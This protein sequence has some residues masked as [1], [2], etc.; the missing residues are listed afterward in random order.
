MKGDSIVIE[1]HHH[2]AAKLIVSKLLSVI[3][4]SSH[5]TISV[6]GESGSGKSETAEAI[7]MKLQEYDINAVILQQDD[8]YFL[9]PKSNDMKRRKDSNWFGKKEVNI[10]LLSEH[11]ANF[12]Q[13]AQSISKP[14]VVYHE[15]KI[16][17]EE[18]S[19]EGTKVLIAEG[20]YTT[21]L[22]NVDCHIFIDRNYDKTREHRE[23]RLR[24]KSE[25]DGF[26]EQILKNEH[27]EISQQKKMADI[28]IDSD[29]KI[30]G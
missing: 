9:P 25:L 22:S 24:A 27:L 13:G 29:Y 14:M 3:K 7:A 30:V 16:E 12:Q 8:Y 11:L 5:Y 6:A 23:K 4:S 17:Q 20:T 18:M 2:D 21:R 19:M 10:E 15:D 1:Q 28:I 26:T